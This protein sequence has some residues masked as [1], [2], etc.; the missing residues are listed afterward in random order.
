MA[1][2]DEII[3]SWSKGG[4]LWVVLALALLLGV[5]HATDPDHLVAVSTLVATEPGRSARRAWGLGLAWGLGH[6]T[7]LMLLGV[8]I[9]LA[10]SHLPAAVQAAA[11]VLVG[12]VIMVIAL[13]LLLRW[14]RGGFHVHEHAHGGVIHRHV[15]AHQGVQQRHEHSH[16]LAR[17]GSQAFVIGLAHGICGSAAVTVLLLA[18]IDSRPEALLALGLFAVGT[19]ASMAALSLSLGYTLGRRACREQLERLA[20]VLGTASFAFGAW[21]AL[22]ALAL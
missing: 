8:P 20:P 13:R 4:S 19:A 11:E 17:S 1:G 7:T 16:A 15:H 12:C 14:R 21:Y 10:G 9:V 6:A 5:R 18:A 3:S 22:G 2:L